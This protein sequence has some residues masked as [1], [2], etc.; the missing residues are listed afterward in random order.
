MIFLRKIL[1]GLFLVL[2]FSCS[3]DLVIDDK[4]PDKKYLE[5]NF[6]SYINDSNV[7]KISDNLNQ[8]SKLNDS[9]LDNDSLQTFYLDPS[10]ETKTY[11]FI[12]LNDFSSKQIFAKYENYFKKNKR[13]VDWANDFSKK[14]DC[15]SEQ[16]QL[17]HSVYENNPY[18]FERE[19]FYKNISFCKFLP[20]I[21]LFD[22]KIFL[23]EDFESSSQ[24]K[25]LVSDSET[26][27][28]DFVMEENSL[29]E[30]NSE[31]MASQIGFLASCNT[32]ISDSFINGLYFD[33]Y[34][35]YISN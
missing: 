32:E 5:I 2:L 35:T 15:F 9:Y 33:V 6:C 22:L 21:N 28:F 11:D 23:E 27:N 19:K 16:K 24:L 34:P 4:Y 17:F 13:F 20:N 8:L 18:S 26:D 30:S 31:P 10:F 29:N 3:E 25:I 1:L 7:S 14:V 12:W